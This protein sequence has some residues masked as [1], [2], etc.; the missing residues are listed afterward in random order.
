MRK[1]SIIHSEDL[2]EGYL[3]PADLQVHQ[4]SEDFTFSEGAQ[5]EEGVTDVSKL[6]LYSLFR[7]IRSMLCL[8]VRLSSLSV[9]EVPPSVLT[10]LV[11]SWYPPS[12]PEQW[13]VPQSSSQVYKHTEEGTV[14]CVVSDPK[15][16]VSLY[17]RPGRTAVA[18]V[19]YEPALGFTG[20]LNDAGHVCVAVKGDKEKE[21][22][23]F[24]VFTVLGKD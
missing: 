9:E 16:N 15:L 5:M 13:F 7:L 22:K 24:Y 10:R 8:L 21:S 6:L 4:L 3:S 2:K 17:E 20:R 1:P 18:E 14:P 12:G 23:V 19:R 11:G